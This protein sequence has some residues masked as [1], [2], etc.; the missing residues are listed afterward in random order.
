MVSNICLFSIIHG[1]ILPI[2]FHIFPRGRSTTNQICSSMQYMNLRFSGSSF[3]MSGCSALL[4]V[5]KGTFPPANMAGKSQ[6]CRKIGDVPA[7]GGEDEIP[8]ALWTWWFSETTFNTLFWGRKMHGGRTFKSLAGVRLNIS[9]GRV[10]R[11]KTWLASNLAMEDASF[12][13]Y[14]VPIKTSIWFG[15]FPASHVWLP[16]GTEWPMIWPGLQTHPF[17]HFISIM[18][19]NFKH[20][21]ATKS[22][23]TCTILLVSML[24]DAEPDRSKWD[25]SSTSVSYPEAANPILGEADPKKDG[26]SDVNGWEW[27]WMVDSYLITIHYTPDSAY[28]YNI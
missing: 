3:G 13:L 5:S 12:I 2:D 28:I 7:T 18:T 20:P 15:D 25:F 24:K 4:R 16:K 14:H 9:T 11:V 10:L 8:E 26:A 21:S 22:A 6:I 19:T 23:S 27:M 17:D 1:I